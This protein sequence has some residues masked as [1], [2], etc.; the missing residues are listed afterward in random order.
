M[1]S[2]EVLGRI[3]GWCAADLCRFLWGLAGRIPADR[4]IVELGVWAGRTACHLAAG[5]QAGHGAHVYAVDL[6]DR[7][8]QRRPPQVD[9]RRLR[10]DA[11]ATARRLGLA[12]DHLTLIQDST[13]GYAARYGGPRVGL[14]FVDAGH[15]QDEVYADVTAWAPHLAGGATVV[16]DDYNGQFP[17]VVAAV[18]HLRDEGIITAPAVRRST[19]GG[20][21]FAVARH[22]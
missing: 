14:L 15:H 7:G 2:L 19:N 4:A 10:L 6:W 20:S 8:G 3:N 18:R 12:P 5:A 9:S 16:F 17:G 22:D 13:V 21:V 1:T 11:H